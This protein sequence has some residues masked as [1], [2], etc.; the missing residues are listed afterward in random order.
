M[1]VINTAFGPISLGGNT[2][3]AIG[4]DTAFGSFSLGLGSDMAEAQQMAPF[5][6]PA[7]QQQGMAW[8]ESLIAYGATRAIDNRFGPVNVAG[9]TQPGTFAGQN[10]RTYTQTPTVQSGQ[11]VARA[12]V[13]QTQ[14]ANGVGVLAALAAAA[15][16]FMG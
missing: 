12:Q 9:N 13:Q 15:F 5:A 1:D 2:T 11:P 7:A 6:P 16:A 10:G 8:W 14:Q 3:P 4:T